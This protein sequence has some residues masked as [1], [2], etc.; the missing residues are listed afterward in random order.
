MHR[1]GI[2]YGSNVRNKKGDTDLR[3]S[4]SL[5][6]ASSALLGPLVLRAAPHCR[7]P[8]MRRPS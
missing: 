8:E 4:P 7:S 3:S 2:H 5:A 6:G 1:Y